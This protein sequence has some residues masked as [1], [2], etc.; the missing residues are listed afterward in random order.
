MPKSKKTNPC[1]DST[2]T[3]RII[4]HNETLELAD[5]KMSKKQ[6]QSALQDQSYSMFPYQCQ[7]TAPLP[8]GTHIHQDFPNP[9]LDQWRGVR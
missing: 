4:A 7:C 9:Q 1:R 2:M 8:F 5:T 3:K 6:Q